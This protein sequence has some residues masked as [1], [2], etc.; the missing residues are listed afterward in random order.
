MQI[1]K[2]NYLKNNQIDF[3]FIDQQEIK[4]FIKRL[5]C[6]VIQIIQLF[7]SLLFFNDQF[8]LALFFSNDITSI[9]QEFIQL[10]IE[11]FPAL[12]SELIEDKKPI[13]QGMMVSLSY[14]RSIKLK[15]L[16]I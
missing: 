12:L 14:L 13:N 7:N 11:F 3:L 10:N 9:Q 1:N 5:L 15:S 16:T 6:T 8:N 2:E 4:I